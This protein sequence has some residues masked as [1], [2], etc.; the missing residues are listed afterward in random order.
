MKDKINIAYYNRAKRRQAEPV[1][2]K[3]ARIL[4]L[5]P[6]PVFDR[7]SVRRGH[8]MPHK[9]R[10]SIPLWAT[11]NKDYFDHYVI[12]ETIH[13][14][15]TTRSHCKRFRLA[16]E[17]VNREFGFELLYSIGNTQDFPYPYEIYRND[18]LI[19]SKPLAIEYTQK[20]A[21]LK[22]RLS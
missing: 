18:S 6:T 2:A 1:I 21:K 11:I 20:A 14:L 8:A 22:Q 9:N 19:Y 4:G 15:K 5:S 16:E 13:C 17:V 3:T 7:V 10:F 12:H